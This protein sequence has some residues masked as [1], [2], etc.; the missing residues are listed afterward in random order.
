MR[1]LMELFKFG[2]LEEG[3]PY[4]VLDEREIRASAGILLFLGT[5]ASINAFLLERY[6]VVPYLAGFIALNF[7]IG[8][9]LNP[10]WA[11]TMLLARIAT[12][13][14]SPLPIGAVQKKFAWSL[15]LGLSLI[16][17]TLSLFLLDN[18]LYFEPVCM[19]CIL[20]LF[21]L[22]FESAFGICIGCKLYDLF[23]FLRIIKKPEVRPN[24][25]GD[26]CNYD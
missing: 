19:L 5:L 4:R 1:A 13:R 14:Q 9:F 7:I 11:P 15:G 24:C 8:L 18:S 3:I 16:I 2:D 22:F 25:V 17:F 26:S 20:C 6:I 10:R 23:I 21:L 12:F